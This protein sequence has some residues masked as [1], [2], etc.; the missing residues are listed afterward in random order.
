VLSNPIRLVDP[1]GLLFETFISE[2]DSKNKK[3]KW[4]FD[5]TTEHDSY[6][7]VLFYMEF[8]SEKEGDNYCLYIDELQAH[9]A[10]IDADEESCSCLGRRC[11]CGTGADEGFFRV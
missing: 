9:A 4:F 11:A 2:A 6:A 1:S 5:L 10:F 3:P 7:A 8:T